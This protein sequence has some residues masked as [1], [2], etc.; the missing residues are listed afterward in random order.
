MGLRTE[1]V[2][3]VLEW[4][5]QSGYHGASPSK[6]LGGVC[7][8]SPAPCGSLGDPWACGSTARVSACLHTALPVW[9]QIYPSHKDTVILD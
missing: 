4:G 1:A 9:I 5:P 8:S 7:A 2:L 3:R 6:G